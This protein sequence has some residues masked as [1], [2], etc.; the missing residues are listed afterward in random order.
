[1]SSPERISTLTLYVTV[2]RSLNRPR[3]INTPYD[4]LRISENQERVE[5]FKV[6][7]HDLDLRVS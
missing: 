5:I 6:E 4:E 3:L 2:E 1:M 7:G